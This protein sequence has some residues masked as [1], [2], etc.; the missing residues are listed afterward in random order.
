MW[1]V[2]EEFKVIIGGNTYIN[3]PNILVYK[4]QPVFTVKR[5]DSD[6]LLGIGFDLFDDEGNRIATIRNGIVVQGDEDDYKIHKG[7]DRYT[8]TEN[9]TQRIVCDL[10]KRSEA[11]TSELELAVKLYLPDGFLFDA[12]PTETN[13]RSM[14]LIGNTFTGVKNGISIGDNGFALPSVNERTETP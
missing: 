13:L 8:V 5:S 12:S 3:V 9:A 4:G 6:G 10:R 11:P 1:Y 7:M 2:E 14:R